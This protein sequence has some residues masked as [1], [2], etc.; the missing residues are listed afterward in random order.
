[1]FPR[2]VGLLLISSL[3]FPAAGWAQS[4][5]RSVPDLSGSVRVVLERTNAFRVA[6]GKARVTMNKELTAA[7]Q[8][9]A[10]YMA[11]NEKY[12]HS[13]DGREPGERA[14]E[15]GYEFGLI[16]EN[17]AWVINSAGF[18]TQELGEHFFQGWKDSP[19][20]RK[21]MLDPD[22]LETGVAIARGS[23]SGRYY[24]VQMFGRPQSKGIGFEVRNQ[25]DKTVEYNVDDQTFTL[26]P[27]YTRTHTS[28][29]PPTVQ[30]RFA[31]GAGAR[32][33]R[34]M[35]GERYLISREPSG[36]WRLSV[37]R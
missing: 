11:L 20:H 25:G 19:G 17:I 1:M 8:Y 7:A 5:A 35:G 2:K 6:E 14:K 4:P 37:G 27:R 13:A 16:S 28:G 32:T 23:K 31:E 33:V 9:F 26:P 21:N 3:L 24:A 12:G 18:T 22:V 15:Y 30:F 34:P 36:E 10:D 29:R